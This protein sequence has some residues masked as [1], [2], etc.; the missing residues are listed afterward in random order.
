MNCLNKKTT[1]RKKSEPA[2]VQFLRVIKFEDYWKGA[3]RKISC[4]FHESDFFP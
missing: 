4:E 2:K 1:L 3:M